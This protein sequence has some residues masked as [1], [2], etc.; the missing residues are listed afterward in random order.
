MYNRRFGQCIN[1]KK[2]FQGRMDK[3]FCSRYCKNFYNNEK[4]N[5]VIFRAINRILSKNRRVLDVCLRGEE[6]IKVPKE[7]LLLLEFNFDYI[8]HSYT[9]KKGDVYNF[10][11]EMGYIEV[12]ESK[13]LIV[14]NSKQMVFDKHHVLRF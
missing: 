11:Y 4:K 6:Y 13:Y 10:C 1:C 5:S 7:K 12:E 3:K 14:N 9:N 8:T 2:P